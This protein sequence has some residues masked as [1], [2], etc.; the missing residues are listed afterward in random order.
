MLHIF[1]IRSKNSCYPGQSSGTW[2]LSQTDQDASLSQ[3]NRTPFA[4]FA[5]DITSL[6]RYLLRNLVA[7]QEKKQVWHPRRTGSLQANENK[8]SYWV[9]S[10]SKK[11]ISETWHEAGSPI[12]L[13]RSECSKCAKRK[14]QVLQCLLCKISHSTLQMKP[15]SFNMCIYQDFL[16]Y[17]FIQQTFLCKATGP[18]SDLHSPKCF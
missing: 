10:S 2:S 1:Q 17:I 12:V 5:P 3:Q 7:K 9:D 15:S 6:F 16:Y 11:D 4:D 8:S 18:S 13:K 14:E